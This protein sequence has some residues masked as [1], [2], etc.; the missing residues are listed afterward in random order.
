MFRPIFII[1]CAV[2]AGLVCP[3][4]GWSVG[5][6]AIQKQAEPDKTAAS[7]AMIVTATE[8]LA[9]RKWVADLMKAAHST[10]PNYLPVADF[11]I[12]M[13]PGS[14][15]NPNYNCRIY[16]VCQSD[17]RFDTMPCPE[18]L[19]FSD[20]LQLCDWPKNV[21]K[22]CG[23]INYIQPMIR[24]ASSALFPSILPAPPSPHPTVSPP[25]LSSQ[26]LKLPEVLVQEVRRHKPISPTKFPAELRLLS[27]WS[28][29]FPY[30][31]KKQI[32]EM[33]PVRDRSWARHNRPK[34]V[35]SQSFSP[36]RTFLYAR[37]ALGNKY[38]RSRS[39]AGSRRYLSP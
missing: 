32:R 31:L 4:A 16:H 35:R 27:S 10:Q 33:A 14:Y 2:V 15:G 36:V 30:H 22:Y 12:H 26:D 34:N 23:T 7:E 11:C 19:K 17:G 6:V 29:L 8:N 1:S 21:D 39:V 38:W 18:T 37:K 13:R 25:M 5:G 28:S 20:Q 3:V 9:K 24:S